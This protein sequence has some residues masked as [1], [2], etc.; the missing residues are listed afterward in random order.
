[1]SHTSPHVPGSIQEGGELGYSLVHAYGA[2]LDDP[3]LVVACVIG[4]GEAETAA[5]SASWQ[6]AGFLDPRTDGAV[7]PILHLNGWK[8]DNPTVMDRMPE[9]QL[10]DLMSGHGH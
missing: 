9:H 6:S 3:D 5:L 7:L 1:P 4:D 2:A 8:I 10:R